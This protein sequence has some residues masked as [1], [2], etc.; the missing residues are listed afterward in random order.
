[1]EAPLYLL[2][3]YSQLLTAGL[4]NSGLA[5]LEHP[6]LVQLIPTIVEKIVFPKI[7]STHT[8]LFAS[9]KNG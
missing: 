7:A 9:F 4:N 2:T 6:V 3:W 8:L 1:V 5:D